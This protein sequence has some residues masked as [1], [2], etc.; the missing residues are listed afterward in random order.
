MGG[1]ANRLAAVPLPVVLGGLAA[2]AMYLPAAHA[3]ALRDHFVARAFFYPGTLLL[4]LTVMLVIA[5]ASPRKERR[6]AQAALLAMVTVYAVLPAVLA[7][8]VQ[9]AMPDVPM[10]DAWFE[11]VAAL[12]TTGATVL[13]LHGEVPA[14]VHLWRGLVG[15]LGGFFWLVAAAALLA[16]LNLGGFEMFAP[17]ST[18]RAAGA[19]QM[20][21]P[22]SS[23]PSRLVHHAAQM[24]PVYAGVTMALWTGL[25]IAGADGLNGL[26]LAMAAISTSGI[27]PGNGLAQSGVGYGGEV[28]VALVL[29][30]ALSRRLLPGSVR[31]DAGQPLWR[32]TELRTAGWLVL[33][34][35]I[36]LFFW[37][38]VLLQGQ[39]LRAG[40]VTSLESLWGAI[41]TA[42]S[43]LTT[44]GFVSRGWETAAIWTGVNVPT[45][46][47]M[48]LA[49]MGGGVATTAGGV[50]LLRVHS[51]YSLGQHELAR[52]VEPSL[53]GGGGALARRLRGEGG[54]LA[55]VFFM[56][57]A[58]SLGGLN[59]ALAA[60]GLGFDRGLALS[61]AMLTNTGPL[62][63]AELLAEAPAQGSGFRAVLAAGMVLG[64]LE[65]LALLAVVLPMAWRR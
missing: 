16:P 49:I 40:I 50:K 44:T 28:L 22:L 63:Q 25:L 23:A 39:G 11:M 48:G 6:P 47:L 24:A 32:D 60:L 52:L 29:L 46:V 56:L 5:T 57:F 35:A 31:L 15:W 64:R 53:V 54:F 17:R 27:L 4:I 43:F 26:M 13:S 21:G 51:L 41:F 38:G 33:G 62:A 55:F 30:L 34:T 3:L 1:L 14:S 19:K 18:G 2:L 7:V 10:V 58:L 8:P 12:T 20:D 36:G 9:T 42:L 45:M 65:T 37:Q 61:V 59:M